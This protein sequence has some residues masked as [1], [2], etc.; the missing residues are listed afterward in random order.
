MAAPQLTS[1]DPTLAAPV[2]AALAQVIDPELGIGILELGLVRVVEVTT[3]VVIVTMTTTSP[4]CP[5]GEA[6]IDAVVAQVGAVPGVVDVAVDLTWDPP[7][8]PDDL[9]PA[10]RAELGWPA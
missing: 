1:D 10:A 8:T 3:G 4:A 7:W 5:L 9:S 2:Q 6:L